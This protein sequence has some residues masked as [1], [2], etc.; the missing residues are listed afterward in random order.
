MEAATIW[1][2]AAHISAVLI[3]CAGLFYIPGL[4]AVHPRRRG[5]AFR[6]LRLM[7]R[8]TYI[9][10]MSP[11]AVIAVGSGAGLI[12]VAG[13]EGHWLFL[14]LTLVALMMLFH[15]FC[16]RMVD[17]LSE[18]AARWSSRALMSLLVIPS[19]LIPGVLFL[20]LGKPVLPF[21]PP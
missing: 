6:R 1:L 11:A 18:G 19:L 17:H 10:V 14:K 16:G 21:P 8:F 13:A 15:I 9:G 20:V 7:T 12:Y 3:W 4:F 5:E 2:K